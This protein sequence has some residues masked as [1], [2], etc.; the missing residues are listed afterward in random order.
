MTWTN[1]DP[2]G[3]GLGVAASVLQGQQAGKQAAAEA[4]RQAEQD[5]L[6]AVSGALANTKTIVD[7]DEARARTTGLANTAAHQHAEDVSHGYILPP[8][9]L[10]PEM[11]T[12]APGK[13]PPSNRD[14]AN[15][16]SKLGAFYTKNKA[17]D[18]ASTA[19]GVAEKYGQ[20]A[21]KE[22]ASALALRKEA[23]TEIETQARIHHWTAQEKQA[24][25]DASDKLVIASNH[26]ATSVQNTQAHIAALIRTANIS[27]AARLKAA[28]IGASGAMDRTRYV[29]GR[30]DKRH[31]N[32]EDNTNRRF[33]VTGG[34]KDKAL[35][36]H[37]GKG[38]K[39]RSLTPEQATAIKA[40][41]TSLIQGGTMT[42][43]EVSSQLV[44]V[45][46]LSPDQANDIV[47]QPDDDE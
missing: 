43:A 17:L 1:P 2:F 20:L 39:S 32:T 12:Q 7:T 23:N 45:Y 4:A 37:G 5:R 10:P 38:A 13:P 19:V 34:Y 3:T 46:N 31:Q 28:S 8:G 27:A 6:A 11:P 47:A 9:A 25:K 29:Q 22:E 21:E 42:K 15:Y 44:N 36:T 16:Y 26:D 35:A 40:K 30:E 41:A 33:N 18:A 24:A 14:F